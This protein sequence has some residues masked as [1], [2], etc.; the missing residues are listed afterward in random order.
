[1]HVQFLSLEDP[2]RD[3][4]GNPLQ[5]SVGGIPR[6]RSLAGYHPRA[7]KSRTWPSDW[8]HRHSASSP[9]PRR[10]TTCLNPALWIHPWNSGVN[11]GAWMSTTL[12]G[13]CLWDRP[14]FLFPGTYMHKHHT[15]EDLSQGMFQFLPSFCP[16]FL[17]SRE[18]IKTS[19]VKS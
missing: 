5:Y 4:N 11:S 3:K 17:E 2:L 6:M 13:R 18:V 15:W 12:Q 8:A 16:N 1:M 7:A 10:Q 14:S 19:N 9:K